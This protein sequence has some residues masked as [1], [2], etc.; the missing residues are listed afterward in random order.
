MNI[1][2]TTDTIYALLKDP[3]KGNFE[4]YEGNEAEYTAKMRI[5]FAFEHDERELV[6]NKTNHPNVFRYIQ[7]NNNGYGHAIDGCYFMD[8]WLKIISKDIEAII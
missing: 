5:F 4:N 3:Y 2:T 6:F 8:T 1:T 7:S